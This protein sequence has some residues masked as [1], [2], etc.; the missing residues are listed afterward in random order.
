MS[1]SPYQ[2]RAALT[3]MTFMTDSFY[4]PKLK[5]TDMSIKGVSKKPKICH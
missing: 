4:K 5:K 1:C 3:S 2:T